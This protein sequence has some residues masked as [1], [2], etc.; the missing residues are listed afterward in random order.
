MTT[1]FANC[2]QFL[3]DPSRIIVCPC[4][5]SLIHCYLVLE[6]AK[7]KLSYFVSVADIDAEE[8]VDDSFRKKDFEAEVFRD[9]EA[10]F[11]SRF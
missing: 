5:D 3:S 6:D 7:S 1:F 2:P 4:I 8:R 11:W 9:F 10:E